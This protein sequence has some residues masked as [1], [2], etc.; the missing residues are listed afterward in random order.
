MGVSPEIFMLIVTDPNKHSPQQCFDAT[1]CFHEGFQL[2]K[3]G[4]FQLIM[5]HLDPLTTL[6]PGFLFLSAYTAQLFGRNLK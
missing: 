1:G 4:F 3:I 6:N 2:R 5:L